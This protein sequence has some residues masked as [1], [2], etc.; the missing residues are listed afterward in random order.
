M[1]YIKGMRC[2]FAAAVGIV[3]AAVA[4]P[5]TADGLQAGLWRMT[6]AAE[7]DGIAAPARESMR[8]LTEAEV[9]DLERLFS[10]ISRT[11]NSLCESVENE[12][13]P[14]RL[15]WRLQ[16]KGQL[17]MDVAGEFLFQR[18]DR[19]TA[20]IVASSS[21]LGKLMNRVRTIIAAERV[22]ECQQ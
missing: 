7:I 9:S 4:P 3:I 19:Y 11:T 6:Q 16:C 17:D 12:F 15:K 5:A 14:Q 1:P 21:M 10:P 2:A 18:P 13:T 22:G 20:T 8:C